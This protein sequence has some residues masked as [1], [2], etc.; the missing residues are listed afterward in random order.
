MKSK[1]FTLIE[2]LMV[3]A[4]IGIL[5]SVVLGSL[6]RARTKADDAAIKS[7]LTN[8]RQM[9]S[10][11]YDDNG[12]LYA[13]TDYSLGACPTAV[14]SGNIFADGKIF[15]AI[16]SSYAKVGGSSN[17]QCVASATAWAVAVVLK[18]SDG[19]TGSNPDAW[20]VDSTGSARSYTYAS[21]Q[22]IANAITVDACS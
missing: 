10:I 13:T 5:A 14:S 2:L 8:I 20:C 17:S 11:W 16:S 1:G 12:Q 22:T 3:I 9:A 4:I 7:N 18:T 21:G 19:N 6:T 15:S